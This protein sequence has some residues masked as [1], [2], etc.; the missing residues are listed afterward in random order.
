MIMESR[1]EKKDPSPGSTLD[2]HVGGGATADKTRCTNGKRPVK[3]VLTGFPLPGEIP[4]MDLREGSSAG[5]TLTAAFWL[6]GSIGQERKRG[7]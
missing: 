4:G 1:W 6:R 3:Y 7:K 5:V 2:I